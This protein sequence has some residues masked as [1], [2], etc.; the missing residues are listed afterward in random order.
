MDGNFIHARWT[1]TCR[2]FSALSGGSS[3]TGSRLAESHPD[4]LAFLRLIMHAMQPNSNFAPWGVAAKS[5][6]RYTQTYIK[7]LEKR[8]WQI[9]RGIKRKSGVYQLCASHCGG[10]NFYISNNYFWISV[11]VNMCGCLWIKRITRAKNTIAQLNA[12]KSIISNKG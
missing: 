5:S 9:S 6:Y 2:P 12:C 3:E 1:V 4:V 11:C 10:R 7:R 8:A